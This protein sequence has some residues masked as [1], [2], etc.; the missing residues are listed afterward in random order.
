M[1]EVKGQ[2][3]QGPTGV[4]AL[5]SEVTAAGRLGTASQGL[6]WTGHPQTYIPFTIGSSVWS[7]IVIEG[8]NFSHK[9]R[10]K[11]WST[12]RLQI[13]EMTVGAE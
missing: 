12:K 4:S 8:N 5:Y 7:C 13:P 11:N 1:S 10:A 9:F 3:R 2:N 6:P